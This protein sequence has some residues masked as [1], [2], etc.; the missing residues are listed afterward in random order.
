MTEN[1]HLSL[2]PRDV[3]H[4]QF[5]QLIS[6]QSG[7]LQV[8]P[9]VQKALFLSPLVTRQCRCIRLKL[10]QLVNRRLLQV[11]IREKSRSAGRSTHCDR[12]KSRCLGR[13]FSYLILWIVILGE[14]VRLSIH[15]VNRPDRHNRRHWG[16]AQHA[17]CSIHFRDFSK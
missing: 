17:T 1:A 15:Q 6:A 8:L 5:V 9:C 12:I 4:W 16:A 7:P 14:T 2:C 11:E 10:I 13:S 3:D